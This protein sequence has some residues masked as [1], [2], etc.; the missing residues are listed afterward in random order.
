MRVLSLLAVLLA[1]AAGYLWLRGSGGGDGIVSGVPSIGGPFTLINAEGKPVTDR[2]F[3]GK[4]MLIYFGYTFCPDICP[5]TLAKMAAAL[6]K[7]GAKAD[8]VQPLFITIDPRRD[9]PSLIGQYTAAL[10]SRLIGLTGTAEQVASVE[11]EY[12]VYA[13]EHRTGN[14]P[15]DYTMD[16]SEIVYL[17]GPDGRFV[18]VI[19]ADD[20]ADA[21]AADISKSLR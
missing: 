12:R 9:T 18:A 17:M 11:K 14:G 3:L 5:T 6:D 7:L 2:D 4:Y 21:M 13:A 19:R 16:H 1:G 20:D 8:R 10:S 15:D